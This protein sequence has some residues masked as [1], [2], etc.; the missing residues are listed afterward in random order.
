MTIEMLA[1]ILRKSPD[2]S[3]SLQYDAKRKQ[4]CVGIDSDEPGFVSEIYR[5]IELSRA[6]TNAAESMNNE[7]KEED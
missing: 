5:S 7:G 1:D 2:R 4:F 3:F 6:L